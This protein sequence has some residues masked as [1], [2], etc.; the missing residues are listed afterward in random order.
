MN[1][2]HDHV[3]FVANFLVTAAA[4]AASRSTSENN[5]GGGELYIRERALRLPSD[6]NHLNIFC[7]PS[8]RRQN[9]LFR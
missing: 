1:L 4:S 6:L 7:S 9:A 2:K 3:Y 5:V 8:S